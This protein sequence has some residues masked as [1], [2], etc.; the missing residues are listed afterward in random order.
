VL[1][2]VVY[3]VEIVEPTVPACPLT[4]AYPSLCEGPH[5]NAI[6][7]H[8]VAEVLY[9]YPMLTCCYAVNDVLVLAWGGETIGVIG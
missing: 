4:I 5:L 6:G 1:V 9:L 2:A 3:A 7:I 8:P